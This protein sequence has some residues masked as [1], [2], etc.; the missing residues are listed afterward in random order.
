MSVYY[1]VAGA[2][3]KADADRAFASCDALADLACEK[4]ADS[5]LLCLDDVGAVQVQTGVLAF[6]GED[7]DGLYVRV[8]KD[9]DVSRPAVPVGGVEWVNTGNGVYFGVDPGW[10]PDDFARDETV[11]GYP[12]ALADGN[13]WV[14]PLARVFPA[15]TALPERMTFGVDGAV[16]REVLPRYIGLSRFAE[17]VYAQLIDA[18]GDDVSRPE[19]EVTAAAVRALGVNYRLGFREV[20]ALGLLTT[21]NRT[22]I[23]HALVDARAM[24]VFLELSADQ[25]KTADDGGADMTGDGSA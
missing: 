25:K 21:G 12:V 22:A 15:G 17:E 14:I 9:G 5:L 1:F 7:V 16:V 10:G 11:A 20:M 4:H 18:D 8:V 2:R 3:S 6:A 24:E 19:P 13:E 23:V